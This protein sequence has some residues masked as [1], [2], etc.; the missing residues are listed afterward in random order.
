[1]FTYLFALG[2]LWFNRNRVVNGEGFLIIV[3]VLSVGLYYVG[4][5]FNLGDLLDGMMYASSYKWVH[6]L[7][8]LILIAFLFKSVQ[9]FKQSKAIVLTRK[10]FTVLIMLL[11]WYVLSMEGK[12]LYTIAGNDAAHRSVLLQQYNKAGLTVLWGT[13]AAIMIWLGIK[14]QHKQLRIL[15]LL[16]F[17]ITLFKLFVSDISG[18][19]EGGK[20]AAFILLGVILLAVSFMYQRL[21]KLIINDAEK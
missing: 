3:L 20:I 1:V 8:V 13:L 11:I 2:V 4:S 7:S 16:L 21:K 19:S 17:G 14:H 15:S 9:I 10:I 5:I 12:W 18:I 6:W